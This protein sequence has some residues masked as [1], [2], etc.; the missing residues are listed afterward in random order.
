MSLLIL[1]YITILFHY[2]LQFIKYRILQGCAEIQNIF[3]ST[4]IEKYFMSEFIKQLKYISIQEGK[5][6]V[7]M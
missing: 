1:I 7:P 6:C 3:L 5:F 4:G 2:N